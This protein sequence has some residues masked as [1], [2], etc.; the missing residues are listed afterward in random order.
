MSK[1]RGGIFLLWIIAF[2]SLGLSGYMFFKSEFI[3]SSESTSPDSGL[4]LVGLWD[5]LAKNKDY[6][7]YTSDTSWLI[8]FSDIQFNNSDYISV[9]YSNTRFKL[10]K[11]GYYKITL[12]LCLE[13][14]NVI[15]N[16][17]YWIVLYRNSTIEHYF[18]RIA[19]AASPSSPYFLI[20][21]SLYVKSTGLDYFVIRC[22]CSGDTFFTIANTQT[23][24]QLSIEYSI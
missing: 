9:S 21:S 22:H 11:E 1:K 3:G 7:P 19:V 15:V 18:E 24:N 10:L 12:L 23:Y 6:L 14:V 20:E 16:S 4:A 5:G 13:M 2:A 17:V 8:E